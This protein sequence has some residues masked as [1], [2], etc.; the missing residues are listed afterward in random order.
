MLNV[1]YILEVNDLEKTYPKS[2]FKLNKI[3]FSIPYGSIMGLVGQNGAGKTTT[4]NCILNIL[5]KKSGTIKLFGKE[6]M[7]GDKDIREDIGVVFDSTNL[8]GELTAN[9][10]SKIMRR[11]YT[12]WDDAVYFSY[13]NKFGLP[14]DR[15]ISTFSTGMTKK[16]SIAVALSH[17]PKLLLLDEATSGLDPVVRD[18]LLDVFLEFVQHEN[19]SILLSSHITSDLEKIADYITFLNQG[20]IILSAQKDELI[21]NYGIIRCNSSQFTNIDKEDIIAWRKRDYQIDVLIANRETVKRKYNS[22]VIDITQIDE[23]MLLLTRGEQ[24]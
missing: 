1:N 23:I 22:L 16:L 4:I 12:R 5:S 19:H 17:S 11:M 2:D 9:R 8:S 24:Q 21:Y 6:M 3:S 13:I 7:D 14:L 15:K 18:D 20:R 10:V